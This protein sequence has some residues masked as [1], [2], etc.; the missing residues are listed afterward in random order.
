MGLIQLV[1]VGILPE[2]HQVLGIQLAGWRGNSA[3]MTARIVRRE[4][5]REVGVPCV[6]VCVCMSVYESVYESVCV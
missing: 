2:F 5:P 6:C 4:S 3:Q 1:H